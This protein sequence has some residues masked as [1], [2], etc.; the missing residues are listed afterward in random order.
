VWFGKIPF[1]GSISY[2]TEFYRERPQ[3]NIEHQLKTGL[4]HRGYICGIDFSFQYPLRY[5]F[6]IDFAFPKQIL[7]VESDGGYWH[8]PIKNRNKDIIRDKILR[9]KGWKIFRFSGEQ[10]MQNTEDCI[11]VITKE[12]ESV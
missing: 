8:Q 9:K 10:I 5:G 3:T 2:M 1:D 6:I 7:A 12:L 11:D 4:E